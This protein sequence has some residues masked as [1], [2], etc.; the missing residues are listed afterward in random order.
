VSPTDSS[1]SHYTCTTSLA[2]RTAKPSRYAGVYTGPSPKP[3]IAGEAE[4]PA[5][6]GSILPQS[7]N[8]LSNTEDS[9]IA[10]HRRQ[11]PSG[12]G[13]RAGMSLG[14][15]GGEL[16]KMFKPVCGPGSLSSWQSTYGFLMKPSG[17]NGI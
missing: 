1:T 5:F 6:R 4:R 3:E 12:L 11:V 17:I 13:R 14:A 9:E 2:I 10:H 16:R 7:A 8:A 15:H